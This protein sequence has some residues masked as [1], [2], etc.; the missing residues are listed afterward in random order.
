ML[1]E[2][3]KGILNLPVIADFYPIIFASN[4]KF[5]KSNLK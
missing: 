1:C 3:I 4:C 5:H 2:I